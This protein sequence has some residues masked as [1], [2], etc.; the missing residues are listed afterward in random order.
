[1]INWLG[2]DAALPPSVPH[3]WLVNLDVWLQ[4]PRCILEAL[5]S[6]SARQPV[7][8]CHTQGHPP[9][10]ISH[11]GIHLSYATR[12]NWAAFAVADR[13][14]GVDVEIVNRDEAVPWHVLH[15]D[16]QAWIK[17]GDMAVR[18]AHVWTGKEA[19]LKALGT[20]LSQ[21]PRDVNTRALESLLHWQ[22]SEPGVSA[23]CC[24]L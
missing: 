15:P 24:V 18:F 7:T 21:E 2:T 22:D 10:C 1:M 5:A 8:V 17:A 13:P 3:A 19:Y 11:A 12:G 14:I 23:C 16:E 9:H 20:G 4:K 6:R